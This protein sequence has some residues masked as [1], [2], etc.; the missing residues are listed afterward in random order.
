MRD[1]S[2]PGRIFGAAILGT[3]SAWMMRLDALL[4]RTLPGLMPW[5]NFIALSATLFSF[6]INDVPFIV[7][8]TSAAYIFCSHM[9]GFM[10][11]YNSGTRDAIRI[12]ADQLTISKSLESKIERL[13]PGQAFS[14]SLP[15]KLEFTV[16][17]TDDFEHILSVAGMKM[18]VVNK[19]DKDNGAGKKEAKDG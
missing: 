8:L 3:V 12:D 2:K 10:K 7:V 19:E 9:D 5:M 6:A 1:M 13:M 14:F 11:G 15:S 18:T 16:V 4:R 17:P